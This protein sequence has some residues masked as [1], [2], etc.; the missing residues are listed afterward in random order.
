MNTA[1]GWTGHLVLKAVKQAPLQSTWLEKSTRTFPGT[2][3][4]CGLDVTM[5]HSLDFTRM[6]AQLL[7]Q[8]PTGEMVHQDRTITG[9]Y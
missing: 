5:T 9:T 8:Q 2:M 6:D 4:I 7:V 1:C 3:Y